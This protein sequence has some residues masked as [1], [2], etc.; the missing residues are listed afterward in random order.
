MDEVW[1]LHAVC[2]FGNCPP[3]FVVG[4]GGQILE[5]VFL[6]RGARGGG[7]RFFVSWGAGGGGDLG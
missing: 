6:F 2:G 7:A 1:S 4:F 3:T 5:H